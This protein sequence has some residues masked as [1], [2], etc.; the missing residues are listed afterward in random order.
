MNESFTVTMPDGQTKQLVYR[1]SSD[2]VPSGWYVGEAGGPLFS[3]AIEIGAP[4]KFDEADLDRLRSLPN[5]IGSSVELQKFE[6]P[7]VTPDGMLVTHV[8][9]IVLSVEVLRKLTFETK[10]LLN[11]QED[12]V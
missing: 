4:Y 8:D 11:S 7:R 1:L 3:V 6:V 9:S 2:E 5:R 10:V 12:L